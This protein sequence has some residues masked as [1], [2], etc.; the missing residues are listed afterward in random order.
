MRCAQQMSISRRSK[1]KKS[2]SISS[3]RETQSCHSSG[4]GPPVARELASVQKARVLSAQFR[5]FYSGRSF[6]RLARRC[7][8]G[9]GEHLSQACHFSSAYGMAPIHRDLAVFRKLARHL[10][11]FGLSIPIALSSDW[12]GGRSRTLANVCLKFA[13]SCHGL[14]ITAAI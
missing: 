10:L 12:R 8:C 14:T 3:S 13:F 7:P 5:T 4:R 2:R 6:I 1:C 11:N 9:L